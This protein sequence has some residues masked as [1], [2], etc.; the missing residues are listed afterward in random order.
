[1]RARPGHRRGTASAAPVII[2][3]ICVAV[4]VIATSAGW[5]LAMT[6]RADRDSLRAKAQALEADRDGIAAQL[7]GA[8]KELADTQAKLAEKS[9]VPF[10][11]TY[12]NAITGP[13]LVLQ[14]TNRS[15]KALSAV[16][17]FVN[18]TLK[19]QKTVDLVLRPGQ[20]QQVGYTDGW[21]FASG[22]QITITSGDFAP[23]EAR[24]P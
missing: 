19:K 21:P 7:D 2:L 3:S 13:G 6:A 16:A 18:P 9:R 24:V 10:S 12:R 20:M 14:I 22:D 1:M 15:D 23:L 8:Q 4:L 17:N 5:Y 11:L